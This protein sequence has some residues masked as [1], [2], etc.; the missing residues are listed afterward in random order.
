VA[1]C[2]GE[3]ALSVRR[4]V[5]GAAAIEAGCT[6]PVPYGISI[7]IGLSKHSKI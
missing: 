1:A 5:L 3:I 7:R 4:V 2:G 6:C